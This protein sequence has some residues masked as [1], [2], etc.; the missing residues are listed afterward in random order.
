ML[1]VEIRFFEVQN[2]GFPDC[3][4]Y[5]ERYNKNEKKELKGV[6]IIFRF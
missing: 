6:E 4:N 1:I 3:I 2:Q 5:R